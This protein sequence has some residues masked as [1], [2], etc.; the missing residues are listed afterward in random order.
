MRDRSQ[1][2]PPGTRPPKLPTES[3]ASE[4]IAG[5]DRFNFRL[6]LAPMAETEYREDKGMIES[7]DIY[8]AAIR[9]AH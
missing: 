1:T 6:I 4:I 5:Q 2:R 7:A 8:L 3:Y 9:T